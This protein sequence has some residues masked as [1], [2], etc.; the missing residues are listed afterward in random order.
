MLFPI[1]ATIKSF[2]FFV[3]NSFFGNTYKK[4]DGMEIVGESA[5]PRVLRFEHF[6]GDAYKKRMDRGRK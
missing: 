3:L 1:T 5:T 4:D 6:F 2:V